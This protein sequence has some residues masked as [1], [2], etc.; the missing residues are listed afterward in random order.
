MPSTEPASRAVFPSI[1]GPFAAFG[2]A[3]GFFAILALGWLRP[4]A[5]DVSPLAPML[6]TA[7]A[8]ALLGRTLRTFPRL[9]DPFAP[10]EVVVFW[11]A[12]FTAAAGAASGAVVGFVTWGEDGVSR[13]AAGGA[14][15]GLAFTPSCLVVFDAARRAGRGR[16][17]SLVAGADQRTVLATVLAGIAFA[18]ATQVPTILAAQIS[19]HVPPLFQLASSVAACLGATAGIAALHRRDVAAREALHALTKEAAWLDRVEG[20][21][22]GDDA[23]LPEGAVDLGLGDD[24]WART[25]DASYRSAARTDVLVKGSALEANAAFDECARRRHRALLVAASGLTAI[26]V[27][28]LLRL[29][30]LS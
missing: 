24:H 22:E 16:L 29:S 13:F 14:G 21:P 9:Q 20:P 23:S 3:A 5:R 19:T 15:V 17:G 6:A 18:G 10:R 12:A 8:G 28:S 30:V 7:A 4:A 11:V 27:A 26:V 25:S 1:A 2:A